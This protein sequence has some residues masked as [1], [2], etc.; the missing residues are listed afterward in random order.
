MPLRFPGQYYDAET[1]FHYNNQRYYDPALGRYLKADPIGLD[2]GLNVYAYAGSN[3]VN[4]FDPTGNLLKGLERVSE[5]LIKAAEESVR[6][7]NKRYAGTVHPKTGIP[8][9]EKGFPDFSSVARATVTI[10]GTGNRTQDFILANKAAGFV[11]TPVGY[12]WHHVEDAV[13]MQLVRTDIHDATRHTGGIAILK[14]A[15]A[16]ATLLYSDIS[17]ASA[18]DYL[19]F[20]AEMLTPL[21]LESSDAGGALYGPGTDYPTYTDYVKSLEQ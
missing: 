11:E 9:N 16:M 4:L 5:A 6:I 7:V 12:T 19:E 15:A 2:G 14:R 13:T 10:K 21:G 17:N 20:T 1:G 8:F 18:N 3:P